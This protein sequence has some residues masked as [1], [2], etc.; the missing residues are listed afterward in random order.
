MIK[1]QSTAGRF[2]AFVLLCSF[3]TQSS[4]ADE[5]VTML[6][7]ME[8]DLQENFPTIL[9]LSYDQLIESEMARRLGDFQN[10]I[11]NTVSGLSYSTTQ[12]HEINNYLQVGAGKGWSENSWASI[13]W[14][15]Y[16]AKKIFNDSKTLGVA[17]GMLGRYWK[18]RCD[19]KHFENY[20]A[21]YNPITLF[22]RDNFT[23]DLPLQNP[24]LYFGVSVS[25]SDGKTIASG[26]I[27]PQNEEEE[28]ILS[29]ST[30]VGASLGSLFSP[31]G[32][33]IGAVIGAIVGTLINVFRGAWAAH[34]SHAKQ[35]II[36]ERI[37]DYIMEQIE[38]LANERAKLFKDACRNLV[39]EETNKEIESLLALLI[40]RQ[41][42]LQ[43]NSQQL[44]NYLEAEAA[45]FPDKLQAHFKDLE[46][47]YFSDLS[48]KM[49][50]NQNQ[51]LQDLSEIDKLGVLFQKD[52]LL[53]A[54]KFERNAK[55]PIARLERREELWHNK[56]IGDVIFSRTRDSL[57]I[58]DDRIGLWRESSDLVNE[59]IR[60]NL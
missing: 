11:V 49:S 21:L 3:C 60:G 47:G 52:T 5:G 27:A 13:N 18:E 36:K 35:R 2:L 32:T 48:E 40:E 39:T 33:V 34:S 19:K 14:T 22:P 24:P 4:F 53:P 43:K 59:I 54:I 46:T 30:A 42:E 12:L 6:E 56:I 23:P 58:D 15:R 7:N 50:E 25:Q 20:L 51:Y 1:P 10:S 38:G 8:K 9:S 45:A 57:L 55:S 26:G 16:A 17:V 31:I 37:R 44:H 29:T 28:A 41:Q